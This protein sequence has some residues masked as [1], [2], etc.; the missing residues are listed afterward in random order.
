[1]YVLLFNLNKTCYYRDYR[2]NMLYYRDIEFTIIAQAYLQCTQQ[3]LNHQGIR[4]YDCVS[5]QNCI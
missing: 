4:V 5:A 3:W 1:M 2:D